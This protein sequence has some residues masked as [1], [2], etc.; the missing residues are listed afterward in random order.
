MNAVDIAIPTYVYGLSVGALK[1][2]CSAHG[3]HNFG[4]PT[5]QLKCCSSLAKC[6]YLIGKCGSL[7]RQNS[8]LD[9]RQPQHKIRVDRFIRSFKRS[10][11]PSCLGALLLATSYIMG[12][13][14][15]I[16]T[17]PGSAL[18]DEANS[19][20]ESPGNAIK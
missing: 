15:E 9:G 20:I 19:W 7:V 5:D 17:S 10:F 6:P 16:L 4:F 13:W 2:C 11:V 18:C 8:E 12:R 1:C 3:P 14:S